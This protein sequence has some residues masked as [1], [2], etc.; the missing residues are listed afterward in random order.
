MN[1]LQ[2]DDIHI[3]YGSTAVVQGLGFSIAKGDIACLLG[4]SACG[5][6]T[7]LR[8]IAGLERIRSGQIVLAGRTVSSS[9]EHLAP[10]ARGI[11]MVFQDYALFP[12]LTVA[13]NI[14]F[15]LKGRTP[16]QRDARVAE[17]LELVGLAGVA[18]R[19]PHE[20]SGGQQQRVALARALAPEPE[21][22]LLD[23]PFSNLDVELRERLAQEV[24]T[25]LKQTGTTALLV[26]HD[27]HEA[28]AISDVVGVMHQGVIRQ[29]ATPYQLYHEPTD[30]F[31]ANF[32]GEG[33]L[34]PGKVTG[35]QCVEFELGEICSVVPRAC[36]P[37]CH[38]D[39]QI[40]VLVRPDD[41]QHDDASPLKATVLARAFR[42]AQFLYTLGLP[43]GHKVLSLVPSHHD[44]RIGEAIGIR[45]EI[46]HVIAFPRLS[47]AHGHA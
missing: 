33:V 12:H 47:T 34:L 11:G 41:I 13:G 3:S 21:L 9:S 29:W 23:E 37:D 14:A 16:A 46:D 4:H 44:H 31:V 32:I 6:T 19:Y 40:D 39:G 8:A 28:F 18:A 20:L 27:Q 42:G 22:L 2:L 1:C 43:S 10:E 5:K 35:P 36:C 24:R 30:R 15:G 7:V 25:I 26:T 38:A 17:L 45:M